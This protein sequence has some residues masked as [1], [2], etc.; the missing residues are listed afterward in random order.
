MENEVARLKQ[1]KNK[2]SSLAG[3]DLEFNTRIDGSEADV[4][5]AKD[6]EI[7]RLKK[8]LNGFKIDLLGMRLPANTSAYL[9][10]PIKANDGEDLDQLDVLSRMLPQPPS[11][12]TSNGILRKEFKKLVASIQDQY[13]VELEEERMK[14]RHLEERIAKMQI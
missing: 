5:S 10:S 2:S 13:E 8:E 6:R 12:G 3:S 1:N 7:L 4:L 14:R 11:S 9:L